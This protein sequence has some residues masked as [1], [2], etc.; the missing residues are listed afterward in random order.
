MVRDQLHG[1]YLLL[2]LVN[3]PVNDRSLV[4]A[5]DDRILL[6]VDLYHRNSRFMLLD[7]LKECSLE[8]YGAIVVA[9]VQDSSFNALHFLLVDED[10][11]RH[12]KGLAPL[13]GGLDG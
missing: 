9:A 10:A 3:F 1:G 11:K 12:V 8:T 5:C 6:L 7:G 2:F 4:L 13:G